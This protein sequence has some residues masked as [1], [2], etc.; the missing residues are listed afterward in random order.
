MKGLELAKAYFEEY[1]KPMLKSDFPTLWP[2]LAVGLAGSGSECF[3]YD[4]ELSRD[5]DF[6]PGFCI[7]LPD[8][9]CVD[10]QAEFRLQRAYTHLPQEFMGFKRTPLSPVGGN[11]LGVMRICDFYIKKCGSGDGNLSTEQWLMVPEY[12]LAEAVNGEVFYDGAGIFSGIRE[13]LSYYPFDIRL[14]KLAGYL[15]VMGQAGQ[16]NYPRLMKRGETGAAQLAVHTFTDAAMHVIFLLNEKYMPYYKWSFRALKE[17]P[18][19]GK[20][21]ES[22]EYLISSENNEKTKSVK[23]EMIE[24]IG[25]LTA[26]CLRSL[27]LSDAPG[28][29]LETHAYSVN[30]HVKDPMTRNMHILSGVN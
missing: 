29:D 17:L 2:N 3:G 7:F 27:Q 9:E 15:L 16:Y 22:L 19:F 23:T 4:D 8:E 12:A 1:G 5:H 11:R 30:D 24:D 13:K 14:K 6:E 10:A 21:A 28:A 18:K 25:T 26:D 20:L